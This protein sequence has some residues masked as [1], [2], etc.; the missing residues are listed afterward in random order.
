MKNLILLLS[1]FFLDY[2]IFAQEI[3]QISENFEKIQVGK[4]YLRIFKDSTSI[5]TIREVLQQ[6]NKFVP[7]NQESPNYGYSKAAFFAFFIVQNTTNKDKEV[8]VEVDYAVLDDVRFYVFD[9]NERMIRESQT[10]DWYPFEQRDL[11]TRNFVFRVNLPAFSTYKV[12][13]RIRNDST[14]SFPIYVWQPEQFI[15]AENFSMWSF[16]LY[17]GIMLVM[18]LY[19]LFIY[20]VLKEKS[21]LFYILNI[22][23]ILFFQLTFNGIGFQFLWKNLPVF[24]HFNMPMAACLLTIG[25]ITFS[26]E[27]L[28]TAQ[29]Q[30][31]LDK[32]LVILIIIA[33]IGLILSFVMTQRI[34][35][36]VATFMVLP[37]CIAIIYGGF[38]SLKQGFRPARFFVPAWIMYLVGAILVALR[39]LGLAPTNFITTYSIQIGSAIEVILLSLAL[40]DK[41]NTL[42]KEIAQKALEKERLEKEKERERREL[43]EQQNEKLEQLVAER[44]QELYEQNKQITDSIKYA[45][46]IQQAIL[47]SK[48]Q[49][50]RV[51][52]EAFI[53]F[54]PRDIVSGDFYW[55]AEKDNKAIIAVV[56][57]TGHGVPGAFM[58]MIGN[59]LLNQIILE[60]GI[61][62]PAEVLNQLHEEVK[63]ALK[64][65]DL[66]EEGS[67]DGMDI[68]LVV[69]HELHN[70]LEFA[71]ANNS[72]YLIRNGR[73]EEILGD[74]MGIGGV[75]K[76]PDERFHNRVIKL[77]EVDTYV[78]M[79][80]DGYADQ[81][82]GAKGKKFL[83]SNLKKLFVELSKMPSFKAQHL[84]LN[85]TMEEWKGNE[86]QIDDQLIIG[87]KIS[88]TASRQFAEAR[89]GKEWAE[90][91]IAQSFK[92]TR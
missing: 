65:D 3:L 75:R 13:F 11:Q 39:G 63:F 20:S 52:P 30:K 7:P 36:R 56:D 78:Y 12:I 6:E 23:A 80:T 4:K 9:E 67:H 77:G 62:R 69:F 34:V 26:R 21:Y 38:T 28:N 18:L 74:R 88:A 51:F 54:K 44:T 64:Q 60:R 81:L 19:N 87:F 32:I 79:A 61:T 58:S 43:I 14:I 27:F 70:I 16:G 90:R 10:G 15:R 8:F 50:T 47:P 89:K 49:L 42:R 46:R 5:M 72:L 45:Q 82:G 59:T 84:H 53:Y 1:V 33:F 86:K 29:K 76:S 25:S 22:L 57:C 55:F 48:T 91:K 41:I 68:S 37:S 17:Y 73:L 83:H 24:N 71:G 2:S 35:L 31:I 85:K 66:T 92:F 40:A